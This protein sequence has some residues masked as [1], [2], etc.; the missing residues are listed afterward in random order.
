MINTWQKSNS[1][2]EQVSGMTN[3][4]IL[5]FHLSILYVQRDIARIH[6][7]CSFVYWA[8]TRNN[9]KAEELILIERINHL[10]LGR[11]KI[12]SVSYRSSSFWLSSHAAYFNQLPI[13]KRL[14]LIA[15]SYSFRLRPLYSESSSKSAIR[16]FG[17]FLAASWRS[18]ASRRICSAVIWIGAGFL[19]LICVVRYYVKGSN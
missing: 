1:P 4:S 17:A 16:C 7:Q 6:I 5:H 8:S 2:I 10:R 12:T 14:R 3:I 18:F 11:K 15:S 9:K 19:F 13:F